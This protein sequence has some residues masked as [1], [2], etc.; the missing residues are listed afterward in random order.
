MRRIKELQAERQRNEG[1]EVMAAVCLLTPSEL[2]EFGE[3]TDEFRPGGI[4]LPRVSELTVVDRIWGF[5]GG[6]VKGI[7]KNKV[8]SYTPRVIESDG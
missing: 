4:G 2:A 7:I 3:R 6:H 1:N 5:G 8:R